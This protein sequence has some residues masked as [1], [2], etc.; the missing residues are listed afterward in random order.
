VPQRESCVNGLT[1]YGDRIYHVV[2]VITR[3]EIL[4]FQI[5]IFFDIALINFKTIC[6]RKL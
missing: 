5:K 6:G 2:Q 1:N 4:S 3:S